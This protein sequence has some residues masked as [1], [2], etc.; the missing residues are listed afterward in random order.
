MEEQAA[1]LD[2]LRKNAG[3]M[4]VLGLLM[5]LAGVF[6]L[7]TPWLMAAWIVILSGVVLCVGGVFEMVHAFRAAEAKF[8]HFL[9]GLLG[10][11]AGL[12]LLFR[13]ESGFAFLTL[14]LFWF[15]LLEGVGN[16]GLAM[17]MKPRQGWGWMLFSGIVSLLL[18]LLVLRGWPLSGG[19]LV[20]I[21]TG[22]FFLFRGGALVAL[23]GAVRQAAKEAA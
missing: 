12:I 17:R 2:V 11:V 15:F 14:V 18:G 21:Y 5:M 1:D 7:M 16:I 3:W 10:L 4:M 22:I 19:L 23:G 20:G 13:P 8:W 6:A 9:F